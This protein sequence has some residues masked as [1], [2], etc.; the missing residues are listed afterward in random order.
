MVRQAPDSQTSR[1]RRL[2]RTAGVLLIALV[3]YLSLRP[4]PFEEPPPGLDK[5]EHALAYGTL[6]F[7]FAHLVPPG[8]G[9]MRLAWGLAGMGVA[10]ECLQGLIGHR[11]FSV[12]DM[13]ANGLGVLIGWLAAPPRSP[14]ALGFLEAREGR[15]WR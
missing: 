4:Q 10:V 5:F 7:W 15:R 9:R 13:A 1:V 2:W 11:L 3:L 6:M 14:D 12:A 8:R